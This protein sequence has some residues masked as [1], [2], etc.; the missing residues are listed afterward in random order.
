MRLSSAKFKILSAI[1]RDI[2]QVCFA[3]MFIAPLLKGINS[4]AE[5]LVTV[6][7]LLVAIFSWWISLML[8]KD[9]E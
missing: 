9:N 3:S 6:L 1:F 4:W 8:T 5:W 2:G 7:G